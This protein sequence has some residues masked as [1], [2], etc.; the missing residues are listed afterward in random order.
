MA[1]SY[2]QFLEFQEKKMIEKYQK[3]IYIKIII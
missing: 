1:Y 3:E 2:L